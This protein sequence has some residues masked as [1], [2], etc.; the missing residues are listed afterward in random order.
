MRLIAILALLTAVCTAERCFADDKE[1]TRTLWVYEGGWF[2]KAK[3]GSWSEFN[4]TAF[5]KLGKPAKFGEAKRTKEFIDLYDDTRRVYVRL[6]EKHAETL[7]RK[8]Q[9]EKLY[10][11]R[12]KKQE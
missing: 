10:T 6:F 4:E 12:W 9:W 2:A 11:G 8:G 3:D 5:R 1:D 7:S